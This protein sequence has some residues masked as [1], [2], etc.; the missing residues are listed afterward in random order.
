[1][2]FEHTH[3]YSGV[4]P[5][6][7]IFTVNTV[8]GSKWISSAVNESGLRATTLDIV[9]P[10]LTDTISEASEESNSACK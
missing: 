3:T 10:D 7:S 5:H 8:V 4:A 6:S 9:Q 2:F 1:M